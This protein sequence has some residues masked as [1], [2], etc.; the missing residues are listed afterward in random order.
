VSVVSGDGLLG[1]TSDSKGETG[2]DSLLE[3]GVLHAGMEEIGDDEG[4]LPIE[5]SLSSSASERGP[6]TEGAGAA[7]ESPPSECGPVTEGAGGAA[8]SS[9]SEHE[10]GF[11]KEDTSGARAGGSPLMCGP[12]TAGTA[13]G[14][15]SESAPSLAEGDA[16]GAPVHGP[17]AD[18]AAG[19][20]PPDQGPVAERA[21][22]LSLS[23]DGAGAAK[24]D[25]RGVRGSP[26]ECSVG[27]EWVAVGGSPLFVAGAGGDSLFGELT[28]LSPLAVE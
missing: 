19:G 14:S 27:A 12:G 3:V 7:A 9:S 18:G 24:G 21:T 1:G 15:P 28:V 6:V 8:G 4:D 5:R 2:K 25:A 10:P 13:G 23:E 11:A 20:S 16:V 22:E 17:V 26:P